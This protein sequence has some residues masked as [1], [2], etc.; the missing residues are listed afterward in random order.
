MYAFSRSLGYF[1]GYRNQLNPAN[2]VRI[3]IMASF[4][5]VLLT[6]CREKEVVPSDADLKKICQLALDVDQLQQYYHPEV[7]G[8]VPVVILENPY[9]GH[10]TPLLKKFGKPVLILSREE[11]AKRNI[12]AYM[13]FERLEIGSEG[14]KVEFE[15]PVEGVAALVELQRTGAVWTVTKQWVVEK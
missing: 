13:V 7:D 11:I 6:G 15:Y 1:P 8:R 9:C 14:A 3:A 10:R 5:L 4:F 2:K 12:E